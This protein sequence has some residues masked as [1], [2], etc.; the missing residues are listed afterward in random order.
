MRLTEAGTMVM[1]TCAATRPNRRL[2]FLG[3]VHNA[4]LET[5]VA[6]TRAR[7]GFRITRLLDA[8]RVRGL[9]QSRYWARFH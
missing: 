9:F 7:R 5:A 4:G 2:Q 3:L 6:L 1:P 8:K